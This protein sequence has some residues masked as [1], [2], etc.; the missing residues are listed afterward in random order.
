MKLT[1]LF[2]A[3]TQG[4]VQEIVNPI[5]QLINVIVPVLLGL[6]GSLGLVYCI[7]LGV[8]YARSSDPQEHEQAKKA[9]IHAIIGFVLIFVLL[10]MCRVALPY[11]I[12]YW[13]SYGN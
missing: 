4:Q 2:L 12:D 10:I 3:I 7:L 1:N 13:Q 11:L 8:K 6:V 5:T 9:L